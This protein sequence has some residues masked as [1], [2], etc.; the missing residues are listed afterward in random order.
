LRGPRA[1]L[2]GMWGNS[3]STTGSGMDSERSQASQPAQPTMS[4]ALV[5][6]CDGLCEDVNPG[7]DACFGW[8]AYGAGGSVISKV[9]CHYGSGEG[10]TN[11]VAEYAAVLDALRWAYKSGYRSVHVLTDSQLVVKQ[12]QSAWQC[13]APLLVPL[14][15]RVRRAQELMEVTIDWVPR[16]QNTEA[17]RLSRQAYE[18]VTGKKAPERGSSRGIDEVRTHPKDGPSEPSY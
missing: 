13:N 3:M 2:A 18:R 15:S 16:E 12:I 11:N 14:L 9:A 8:V 17:D 5:I 4:P 6:Y 10:M 1:P 7:G